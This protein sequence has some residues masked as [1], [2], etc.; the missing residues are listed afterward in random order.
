MLG[1]NFNTEEYKNF[2]DMYFEALKNNKPEDDSL[3]EYLSLMRLDVARTFR[4]FGLKFLN[5]DFT[6]G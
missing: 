4:P 1:I 3:N 6:K 5:S 2:S